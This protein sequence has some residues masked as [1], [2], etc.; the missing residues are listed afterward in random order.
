MLGA[1][2]LVYTAESGRHY[3]ESDVAL[4]EE[5]AR[6]AATA[7]D[8]A[9]AFRAA[10]IANQVKSEFLAVMSHELRTPLNAIGGYVELLELELRGPVTDAQRRDLER[11]RVSQQHLLGLISAVLDLSRIESGHVAYRIEP[12]PLDA[13]LRT[14]DA[15]IGP[16]VAAKSLALDFGRCDPALGVL[17][18]REK[19][20]QVVLNLLSNAVRYTPAGGRVSVRAEGRGDLVAIRVEDNGVGIPTDALERIFEPFVQLDRSLTPAR[21]GVGLGLAISRD[22]ARGMAGDLT[23]ASALG[24]GSA[25]T[26]TLPRAPGDAPAA[27]TPTAQLPATRRA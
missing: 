27:W 4:A 15:L 5:L 6:R 19:L 18:D 24:V 11:I 26:L 10:Q 14:M 1:L 22:L 25:F 3:D 9:R 8:H 23:A 12:V 2:T 21:E 7:I 16:Q 17:A 20:R 13:F